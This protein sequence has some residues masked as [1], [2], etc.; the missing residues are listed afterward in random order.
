LPHP[1]SRKVEEWFLW[2]GDDDYTKVE[3]LTPELSRLPTTGVWNIHFLVEKIEDN[4]R[5]EQD[6]A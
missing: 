4:W 2:R 6:A 3:K 1:V 5:P